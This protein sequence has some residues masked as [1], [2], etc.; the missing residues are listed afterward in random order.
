MNTEWIVGRRSVLEAMKAGRELE[1][2]LVA[3]GAAKGGLA[4]LIRQA[5]QKGIPVQQVPRSR[6]DRLAEG[7]NHQGVA[8]EAAA[9]KYA[10]LEDL[11]RRA[12]ER[13]EAPFFI[14]LDG[15]EDPHNLGSILRTA[16]AA[17]A[18]GVIIPK[19]RAAGLTPAVG[20]A[21]AGAVEYVPVVRVTNL[22][23]TA[24]ELKESG[25]WIIGSAPEAASDFTEADYTLP[26]ALV[27]GSEG[28]GMS[29][30]MK[31]TCDL[32]VRLPMAGRVASL[33]ASV[34]AALLMYEVLRRRRGQGDR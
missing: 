7:A 11:F 3:E 26:L 15:I 2:L 16:D 21:S 4:E 29:R 17:G 34:A 5:R 28:R 18:H 10:R 22:H 12:E 25:L 33:N 23:R 14:L 31:E 24:E 30:L 27:I 32:L 19:R 8:A 20:K 6:L 1:K 9:Y 13:E